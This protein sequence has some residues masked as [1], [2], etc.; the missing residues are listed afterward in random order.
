MA[1]VGAWRVAETESMR[2]EAARR[3]DTYELTVSDAQDS[4]AK[5]LADIED[6]IARESD[7]LLI[8]PREYHGLDVAFS[9]ASD[10][11]IPVLLVDREAAGRPGVDYVT[12]L[13]SDFVEQ[14]RRAGE[15]LARRLAE[16]ASIIEL[17][18]TPG[19]SVARDRAIGFR[20]AIEGYPQMRLLGSQSGEFM[21][22]AG[23]NV[24]ANVLQGRRNEFNAVFAHNDE[25]ALGAIQAIRGAG[26]RPGEDIVVVSIDGQRLALQAILRGELGATVESNPRFGPLAFATLD[27]I[28][29]GAP[30]PPKIILEDRLFDV[31][32][33]AR[34]VE[35]AY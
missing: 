16:K 12:F 29:E 4:S 22:S 8:A 13:G 1:N 14:G 6:L 11:R 15:W 30:I 7:A 33:A 27:K 18:G 34:F 5:Q 31:T 23:L 32:N 3:A 24:M 17:S 35:E 20:R 10:A 2:Q 9:A 25:M 28:A 21:R 26:L 19:A